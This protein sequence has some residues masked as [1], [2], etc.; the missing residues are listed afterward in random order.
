MAWAVVWWI[1][2]PGSGAVRYAIGAAGLAVA[3][4]AGALLQQRGRAAA[5]PGHLSLSVSDEEP[6]RGDELVARL[7]ISDPA[8]AGE[9]IEV[10][11]ICR[12]LYDYQQRSSSGSSGVG[13]SAGRTRRVTAESTCFEH[14]QPLARSSLGQEARFRIPPDQPFSFEGGCLSFSWRVTVRE[15]VET[16]IDRTLDRPI[17]VLP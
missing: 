13:S 17:W 14:W 11:L 12:E 7:Q 9:R 3:F 10:G 1:A 5:Q 2:S 4:G 6:R 8:E 15:P 16:G